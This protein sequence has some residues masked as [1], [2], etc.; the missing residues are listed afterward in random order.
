ME[1]VGAIYFILDSCQR[2]NRVK[3]RLCVGAQLFFFYK[4]RFLIGLGGFRQNWGVGR[5][6]AIALRVR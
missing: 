6:C 4:L 3:S 1:L 2:T 5:R